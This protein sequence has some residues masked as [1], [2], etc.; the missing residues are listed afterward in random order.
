M[1]GRLQSPIAQA[2][3]GIIDREP[4]IGHAA[5]CDQRQTLL[6]ERFGQIDRELLPAIGVAQVDLAVECR[7]QQRVMQAL[8]IEVV[9]LQGHGQSAIAIAT[10]AGDAAGRLPWRAEQGRH[11]IDDE[12]PLL[13]YDR[14]A[15]LAQRHLAAT[16]QAGVLVLQRNPAS[17]VGGNR[18]IGVDCGLRQAAAEGRQVEGADVEPGIAQRRLRKR[19]HGAAALH[20]R[21]VDCHVD[22]CDHVGQR[23][24]DVDAAIAAH[25]LLLQRGSAAGREVRMQF[26]RFF[27]RKRRLSCQIAGKLAG[28]GR[29]TR[30]EAIELQ[31]IAF[32][33]VIDTQLQRAERN[34]IHRSPCYIA[35]I[36][37]QAIDLDS[38]RQTNVIRQCRRFRF[39]LDLAGDLQPFRMQ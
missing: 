29:G 2:K 30:G 39:L 7:R 18:D 17:A 5:A 28:V 23:A 37:L 9:N 15:Q 21:I 3:F 24:I 13:L 10:A 14:R 11:A 1:A 32:M 6:A 33:V 19:M 35:A 22:F 20:A 38:D 26:I 4:F 27:G 12:L 8:Q 25:G 31:A 34:D 36:D 16:V